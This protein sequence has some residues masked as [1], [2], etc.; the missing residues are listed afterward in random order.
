M[1]GSHTHIYSFISLDPGSI[2]YAVNISPGY[3]QMNIMANPNRMVN[4]VC[5]ICGFLYS[6]PTITKDPSTTASVGS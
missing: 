6:V 1:I 2:S 3:D 5:Q 4:Y